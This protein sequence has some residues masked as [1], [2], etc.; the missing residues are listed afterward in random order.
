MIQKK[1]LFLK[2]KSIDFILKIKKNVFHKFDDL[3]RV[4]RTG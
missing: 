1:I 4:V 2:K 3:E